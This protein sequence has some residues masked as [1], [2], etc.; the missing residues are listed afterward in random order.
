[1][2]QQEAGRLGIDRDEVSAEREAVQRLTG[3]TPG[4]FCRGAQAPQDLEGAPSA[5]S[6]RAGLEVKSSSSVMAKKRSAFSDRVSYF[7]V[8]FLVVTVQLLVDFF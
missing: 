7:T 2:F 6:L 4:D 3:L 5:A 1:M 8:M